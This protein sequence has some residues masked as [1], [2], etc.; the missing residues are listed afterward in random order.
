MLQQVATMRREPASGGE[1]KFPEVFRAGQD[2][3]AILAVFRARRRLIGRQHGFCAGQAFETGGSRPAAVAQ[4]FRNEDRFARHL[5]MRLAAFAS[6]DRGLRH[7]A[8]S[9]VK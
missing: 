5:E 1:A 6:D 9:L 4:A 8:C 3:D 2:F 7:A